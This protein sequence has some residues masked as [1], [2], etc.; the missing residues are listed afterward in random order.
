MP[1]DPIILGL[2]ALAWV[3]GQPDVGPRLLGVTG[4]DADSLRAAAG[5]PATLAAV[6]AFL[7]N[8]EPDLVA[9]ADALDVRPQDLVAARTV[10]E[11]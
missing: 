3:A 9:C 2:Q 4:L 10:L 1:N 8:H 6:L 7:E 5:A 11:S